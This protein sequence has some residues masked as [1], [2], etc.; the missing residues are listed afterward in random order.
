M[1]LTTAEHHLDLGPFESNQERPI[2]TSNIRNTSENSSKMPIKPVVSGTPLGKLDGPSFDGTSS[3]KKLIS[4]FWDLP[5]V[6]LGISSMTLNFKRH[7]NCPKTLTVH[8]YDRYCGRYSEEVEQFCPCCFARYLYD[9]IATYQHL[10]TRC[11]E[12][13]QLVYQP[14][15]YVR[16]RRLTRRDKARIARLRDQLQHTGHFTW[17][18]HVEETHQFLKQ[19]YPQLVQYM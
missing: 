18:I 14:E 16:Q 15:T 1:I 12:T 7:V 5:S 19:H 3:P 2:S 4:G 6:I 13:T 9:W 8:F 11:V 17:S 10:P